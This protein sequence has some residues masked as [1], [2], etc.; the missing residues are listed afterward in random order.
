MVVPFEY[1]LNHI[2][3]ENLVSRELEYCYLGRILESEICKYLYSS[4]DF[5]F[6]LKNYLLVVEK[7]SFFQLHPNICHGSLIE[8][9]DDVQ[10]GVLKEVVCHSLQF[11][12]GL[13]R[14]A[15]IMIEHSSVLVDK[16]RFKNIRC[17]G[18]RI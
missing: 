10:D 16:L 4:Y 14:L 3:S 9:D 6:L 18:F 13:V 5:F 11:S 8:I 2:D 15:R 12:D 7:C 1:E 17:S